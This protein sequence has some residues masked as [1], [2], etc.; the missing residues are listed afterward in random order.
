MTKIYEVTSVHASILER[1]PPILSVEA[2]GTIRTGGWSDGHLSP[3]IYVNPPADGIQE[4]DF[5]ATPPG[6]DVIEVISEIT[7]APYREPCSD[8]VRGVRVYSE[9]N[10]IESSV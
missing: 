1:D 10:E 3:Y 7:A 6:G 2:A 9:T 4:F 5:E 8:W